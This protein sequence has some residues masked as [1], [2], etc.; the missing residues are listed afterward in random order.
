MS[1]E[2]G[3]A[4]QN[5]AKR[6]ALRALEIASAAQ[7]AALSPNF[8]QA[9]GNTGTGTNTVTVTTATITKKGSG[10]MDITASIAGESTGPGTITGQLF[11]DA[12]PIGDPQAVTPLSANDAFA[13]TMVFVDT[14]PDNAVHTYAVQAVAGAGNITCAATSG[15]IKVK[16]L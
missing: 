1:T 14:A 4:D 5:S 6:I 11:R 8:V 15:Q 12:V 10:K 7:A 16:E 2:K 3:N 13:L 9:F